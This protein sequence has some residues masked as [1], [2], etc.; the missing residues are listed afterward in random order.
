MEPLYVTE[1]KKGGLWIAWLDKRKRFNPRAYSSNINSEK[2]KEKVFNEMMNALL[3][4]VKEADKLGHSNEKSESWKK[5]QTELLTRETKTQIWPA[6]LMHCNVMCSRGR[7]AH[8]RFKSVLTNFLSS[9][10]TTSIFT[11][12]S[13]FFP[14]LALVQLWRQRRITEKEEDFWWGGDFAEVSW[15]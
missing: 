6:H 4:R 1:K 10:L 3:N 11:F 5:T 8:L 13:H 14:K 12:V 2:S 9:I 7:T 15:W